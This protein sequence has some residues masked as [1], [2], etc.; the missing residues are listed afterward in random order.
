MPA[1]MPSTAN[2][3]VTV[4]ESFIL[5]NGNSPVRI[6]HIPS[7]SIPRFLPTKLFVNVM[8][9]PPFNVISI[10]ER[11]KLCPFRPQEL[12]TDFVMTKFCADGKASFFF[13]WL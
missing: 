13:Y 7:K 1:T 6:N 8:P 9:N 2:P 12:G 10:S 11:D 4:E 3:V 5:R